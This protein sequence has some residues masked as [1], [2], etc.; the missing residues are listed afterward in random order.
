MLGRASIVSLLVLAFCVVGLP[1]SSEPKPKTR[2][3]TL[4]RKAA[5]D[6]GL[7]IST[8]QVALPDQKNIVW[9]LTGR[10]E[11]AGRAINLRSTTVR[12]A[13]NNSINPR[14]TPTASPAEGA[15]TTYTNDSEM[16]RDDGTLVVDA[17][18]AYNAGAS[19]SRLSVI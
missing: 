3:K 13:F 14:L 8:T 1:T 18:Y 6:P 17:S 9:N 15:E 2:P 19:Q 10:Y 7:S 16:S 12:P 11:S 4:S 5:Q